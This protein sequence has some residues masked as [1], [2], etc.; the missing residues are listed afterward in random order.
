MYKTRPVRSADGKIIHEKFQ[1]KTCDKPVS[2]IKP[3]RRWFGNTKII[4]QKQLQLF[5]NEL[6]KSIKDP[7]KKTKQKKKKV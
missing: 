5:R 3:D 2:R 7:Y 4:T 1:S 6:S